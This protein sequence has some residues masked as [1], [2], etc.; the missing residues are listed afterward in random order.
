MIQGL[1]ETHIQVRDLAK[2]VAFYTE[3]LGLRVA[4]RDPTRPIVFLW[5]GTG[6]DYMLGLW[7]EE[8]N[9]QPRH[10]A[11]RAD[12]EDI[13]NYAVDYLKTR[14]LTPYNFLKDG[15]EAPMVFA[16]M[17]ALAIYF[18]DPDGNQLEF[19]AVLEGAGR[20]ELGVL[21]Y[22]DWINRTTQ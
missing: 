5:I 22:A 2:S 19:I 21:S 20:P 17:P 1:Y 14:D 12:K 10:F 3:V 4:H 15:I 11:F 8:T 9:F 13:L 18:N 7:Q 16:W 6:K